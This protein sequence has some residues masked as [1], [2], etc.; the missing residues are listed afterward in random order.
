MLTRM[1][2]ELS[3]AAGEELMREGDYGYEALFIEEGSVEILQQGAVINELGAGELFGELAVLDG[4]GRRTAS[5][6]ARTPVR[7]IVLTSH[8]LHHVHDR[9]PT[10][11]AAVDAAAAASRERDRARSR[12]S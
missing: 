2:D 12:S 7:A 4:D 6:V 11:A 9:M 3:A 1:S 5:V 8:F 10:V